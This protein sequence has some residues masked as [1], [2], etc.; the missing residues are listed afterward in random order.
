MRKAGI[1]SIVLLLC[2]FLSRSGK[3][4]TAAYLIARDYHYADSLY[5]LD[6][7]NDKTDAAA[8][9][10][11]NNVI[12]IYSD[13]AR[14]PDTTLFHSYWKKGVLAEIIG[15]YDSAKAAYIDALNISKKIPAFTDSLNFK[16]LL[17]LGALYY[18]ENQFD[19]TR[20]VLEK[21][22]ALADKY[23]LTQEVERLYNTLGAL[24]F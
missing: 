20:I 21:A 1:I 6:D 18:R 12:A 24:F 15:K 17:Y 2:F 16:P 23:A 7:P 8:R 9:L 22:E 14:I 10:A 13:S 19:S 4:D 3:T 11:F 5:N